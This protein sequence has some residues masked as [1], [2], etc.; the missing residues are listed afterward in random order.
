MN[1]SN[2]SAARIREKKKLFLAREKRILDAT[3][4]LMMANGVDRVTV[5]AIAK[6]ACVGKG[7]VYKHFLTKEEIL[8]Q[9]ITNYEKHIADR[10]T[11]GIA[12]SEN[13]EPCAGIR[14]YLEA[15]LANPQLDRLMQLIE[16]RMKSA[17]ETAPQ[18]KDFYSLRRQNESDFN[19][20]VTRLIKCG[21]LSDAEPRFHYL[22]RWALAQGAVEVC[23]K[24]N[25]GNK[26]DIENLMSFLTDLGVAMGNRGQGQQSRPQNGS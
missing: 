19:K 22:A 15:R 24:K 8:V 11:A 10:L 4:D 16:M 18:L 5:S 13:G 17:A 2:G 7:T 25:D 3:L 14:A 23:L 1:E 26:I 21:V 12:R 9:I 20:M 6:R